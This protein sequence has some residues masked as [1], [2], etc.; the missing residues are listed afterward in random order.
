MGGK[1]VDEWKQSW[2][3]QYKH[4]ILRHEGEVSLMSAISSKRSEGLRVLYL[5]DR[6]SGGAGESLL[7]LL[8]ERCK[9]GESLVYFVEDGFLNQR[10]RS[11]PLRHAPRFRYSRP[12][13]HYLPKGQFP[14]S[15]LRWGLSVLWHCFSIL[16]LLGVAI[17]WRP[18]LIHT[19]SINFI[20]GALIAKLLRIPHVFHL[21]EL[22]D[23]DY[24]QY[25][26]KKSLIVKWLSWGA[27]KIIC[28]SYRT[29]RGLESLG[30]PLNKIQ[31]LYN[32][33][34]YRVEPKNLKSYLGYSESVRLVA[35][36]GWI[37]PNKRIEDFISLAENLSDLDGNI[38]FVIIG[39]WGSRE[40]YNQK[41]RDRIQKSSVRDKIRL[42]GII[43]GVAAYF[44]SLDVFVCP[45]Y[46][47]SFGRVVAEA[48]A[49]GVPCVAVQG[50]STA[51]GELIEDAKSGFLVDVGDVGSMEK[52]LREILLN[53]ELRRSLGDSAR[54]SMQ[55]FSSEELSNEYENFY[56]SLLRT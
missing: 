23:L 25:D 42:A 19:N 48:M 33:V 8:K 50:H 43:P 35:T 6:P 41:I 24:Y 28:N 17:R 37:S 45:S 31:V 21:R 2:I 52:R 16:R 53:E 34:D 29:A 39:G 47:E 13:L 38:Q 9:Y 14:L 11:L 51:V 49:A 22:M 54:K 26:F 27:N 36:C 10:F 3:R 44:H 32:L 40:A 1:R 56:R 18:D 55:K 7:L 4:V 15:W 5:A 20:D 30:M 46:T 12:W